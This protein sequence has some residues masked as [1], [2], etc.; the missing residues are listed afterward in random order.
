MLSVLDHIQAL[1]TPLKWHSFHPKASI[2][3]E[4]FGLAL[5]WFED[6]DLVFSSAVPQ[7]ESHSM[8]LQLLHYYEIFHPCRPL[9]L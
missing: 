5:K 6:I 1:P 3:Y 2:P 9:L 4:G 8:P 7:C